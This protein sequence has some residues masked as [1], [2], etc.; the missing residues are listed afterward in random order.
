MTDY[1]LR[2][3][4][5]AAT[6]GTP[7]DHAAW[8]RHQR[9]I[10]L[11]H[12]VLMQHGHGY[13]HGSGHGSGNGNGNGN[14]SGSGSGNGNGSGDGYGHG[15]GY[16]NGSG[17]G[18]GDGHGDGHGD[19][20]GRPAQEGNMDYTDFIP[21]GSPVLVRAYTA[22]VVVG[23]L[24]GGSGGDVALSNWRW[25][26]KWEA[27]GI[28]GSCYHLPESGIVPS[29]RGPFTRAPTVFGRAQAMQITEEQ[30]ERLS[31]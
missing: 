12:V 7:E 21:A 31:G 15:Y 5:R 18:Y 9:R 24:L 20:D 17:H 6:V 19:G 13:G 26:R 4:E 22:G 28:E 30:Y 1:R 3:L 11:V 10:G 27:S 23:K 25:L 16:G 14:G 2:E 29:E 8:I